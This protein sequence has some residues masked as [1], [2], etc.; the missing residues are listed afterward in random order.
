MRVAQ[1]DHFALWAGGMIVCCTLGALNANVMATA[2]VTYAM[3]RD[4]V[5]TPWFGRLQNSTGTPRNALLLHGSWTSLLILSGSFQ[6]LAEMYVFITWLV[7]LLGAIGVIYWRYKEPH[8]DRPY[9]V[10]GH[11]Y[12][13][14]FFVLF[15]AAYLLATVYKDISQYCDGKQPVINS[16]LAILIVLAGFPVYMLSRRGRIS[17]E[18][19]D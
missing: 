13:T 10:T 15:A 11:P 17:P 1:G 8:R 6:L 14:W 18:K 2:R 9:K 5:L 3:G 12:L 4:G 16:V 7:Y 19:I